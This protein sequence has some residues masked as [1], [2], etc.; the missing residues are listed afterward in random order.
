MEKLEIIISESQRIL[1]LIKNDPTSISTV[2]TKLIR[3]NH[4]NFM[5]LTKT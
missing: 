3:E 5:Q 4:E 2:E 1:P